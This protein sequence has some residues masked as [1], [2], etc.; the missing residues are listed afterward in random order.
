ML[1][2]TGHYS[3]AAASN[4]NL[5]AS[6][7]VQCP[8]ALKLG[9]QGV[10]ATAVAEANFTIATL[11]NCTISDITGNF[12]ILYPNGTAVYSLY[13]KGINASEEPTL[14]KFYFNASKIPSGTYNAEISFSLA[15]FTNTSSTKILINRPANVTITNFST[16][17]LV[18]Q[19]GIQYFDIG[20]KNNGGFAISNA[21]SWRIRVVEPSNATIGSVSNYSLSPLQ[22]LSIRVA[23][24]NTTALPGV[25]KALLNVSYSVNGVL[26]SK[27]FS[28]NYTVRALPTPA[29]PKVSVTVLPEFSVM[30]YPFA[31]SLYNGGSQSYLID[32]RNNANVTEYF[33]LSVPTPDGKFI[34]LSAYKIA[35]LP[36]QTVGIS[37]LISAPSDA[38]PGQYEIPINITAYI[39]HTYAHE[40]LFTTL[41]ILNYSTGLPA[42][43]I[44]LSNNT[45]DASGVVEITN[46][47]G[48]N[49][50]NAVVKTMLPKPIAHMQQQISAYGLPYS[51]G[52]ENGSYVITWY[53][54][55]LPKL[56]STYGYFSISNI[57]SQ[58]LL[59]QVSGIVSVPSVPTS[60]SL[61]RIIDI[62][63]PEFYANSTNLIS[64]T[65]FYSGTATQQI[66]AYM[67]GQAGVRIYNASQYANA[68]PNSAVQ[69]NFPVRISEAGTQLLGF[70]ASTSGANITESI[71][72]VVLPKQVSTTV[73]P[74]VTTV[75]PSIVTAKNIASYVEIAAIILIIAIIIIGIGMLMNRPRYNKDRAEKLRT[76]KN[77]I[78][79]E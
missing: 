65:I 75:K 2:S 1:G 64:A 23:A 25:Y 58:T 24:A 53:V 4:S 17:S 15:N 69:F 45:N 16:S 26:H 48:S 6:V 34:N 66:S 27:L 13:T 49:M 46:P 39:N 44:T 35:I 54:S 71:P 30:S 70:R 74:T 68:T 9:T 60:T 72:V 12:S 31:V 41:N 18:T 77:A 76:I 37:A 21:I 52:T 3:Y 14:Y 40:L 50:T 59:T 28:L 20:I 5:D 73:P 11:Y 42:V 62:N 55:S 61:L 79:R 33:N 32:M 22:N 63:V 56:S 43:S 8:F 57:T 78:K 38:S 67:S 7:N 10:Y 51:I 19:H 29:P 36:K 47:T